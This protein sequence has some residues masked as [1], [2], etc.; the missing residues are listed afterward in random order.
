MN[1]RNQQKAIRPR[2][3]IRARATPNSP[4]RL[5][6]FSLIE[7]LVVLG[8]I[9]FLTA[10]IV[11]VMPR[12]GNASKIAATQATIKKVDE[13]LND[14]INGFNRWINTQNTLAG[15]NVPS[16][17]GSSPYVSLYQ[18]NQLVA[19]ILATKYAFR[20]SFPQTYAEAGITPPPGGHLGAT[21]SAACLYMIL[22][23]ASVFDTEPPAAADLKGVEVMDT[24]NDGRPEIVDAWGHPLRFYRWPTRLIRAGIPPATPQGLTNAGTANAAYSIL[25]EPQFP[26]PWQPGAV[27]AVGDVVA[28]DPANYLAYTCTVAGTSGTSSPS[29]PNQ[30]NQTV[31]DGGV[32]WQSVGVGG[33]S[34][35]LLIGSVVFQPPASYPVVLPTIAQETSS[36]ALAK[37][38]D[39]PNGLLDTWSNGPQS[40]SAN[41]AMFEQ[42]FHTPDTYFVP[43]IV[44]MGTDEQLGLF[45]PVDSANFGNLCQPRT[46]LPFNDPASV[47]AI[48]DNI[49]NHQK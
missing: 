10:A 48:T 46:D 14:R 37:D 28:P 7:V 16:Y 23:Q 38:P 47:S 6:G 42:N 43:L 3:P 15:N 9:A 29:W 36:I 32:T 11:V 49:T 45:E 12:L 41:A 22:T 8:I 35:R 27:H 39:D 13:L 30:L 25:V 26:V 17:V 5:R 1:R 34:A 24:D 44:S 40:S 4:L 18:Q 19:K 31:T 21:E 20:K 2:R 33:N